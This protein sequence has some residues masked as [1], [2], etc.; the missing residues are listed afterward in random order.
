M[1]GKIAP[2]QFLF[3]TVLV[4]AD[5]DSNASA[6]VGGDAETSGFTETFDDPAVGPTVRQ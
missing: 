5:V 1:L 4:N 2:D 6:R 3:M